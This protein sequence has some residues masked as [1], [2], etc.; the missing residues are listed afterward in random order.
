VSIISREGHERDPRLRGQHKLVSFCEL[1]RTKQCGTI[2]ELRL[3]AS[4]AVYVV[5]AFEEMAEDGQQLGF[6]ELIQ[7]NTESSKGRYRAKRGSADAHSRTRYG[8]RTP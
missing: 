8:R 7:S 6:L 1:I 3:A 4:A 5:A 2:C